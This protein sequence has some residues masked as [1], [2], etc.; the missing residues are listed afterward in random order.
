MSWPSSEREEVNGFSVAPNFKPVLP[1]LPLPGDDEPRK[2]AGHVRADHG[3]RAERRQRRRR[4]F[5]L[6]R[7]AS[8]NADAVELQ[9]GTEVAPELHIIG[10]KMQLIPNEFNFRYTIPVNRTVDMFARP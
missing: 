2:S 8:L 3:G 1:P 5:P 7:H 4:L 6:P 9:S 10:L